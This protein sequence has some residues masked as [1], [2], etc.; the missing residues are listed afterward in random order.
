MS[1]IK[2]RFNWLA[3][4]LICML[5]AA[6]A[7]TDN[8][9]ANKPVAL[10]DGKTFN[11]WE[12]DTKKSFR[13]EDGAIVGGSMKER[14]P[15]N[16]FLCTTRQYTN[17]VLRLKFKLLGEGANAGVQIR[18]QRIPNHHEVIGYQADMGGPKWWGCLYD[19][20]RRKKV[21]A[22][23]DTEAVNKVL[24]VNDWNEYEIRCEGKRVRLAI[25][26]LQTVDYTEPDD[27]IPQF[28]VIAVQIHSGP[29]SEA[30]YKDIVIQELP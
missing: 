15:R 11:G 1:T 8:A 5:V 12:G 29:P 20:S 16:E 3:A 30:W 4:L 25:N 27:A 18:T 7:V 2:S 9:K 28:G 13:I 24:K 17:F 22:Q 23:S 14:I 6:C 26:G 19:E 21:L 10:F